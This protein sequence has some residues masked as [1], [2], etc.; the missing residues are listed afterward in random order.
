M[1]TATTDE[2]LA[3]VVD[4]AGVHGNCFNHIDGGFDRV[5][6]RLGNVETRLGNVENR[7]EGLEG[8]FDELI[9]VARGIDRRLSVVEPR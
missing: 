6:Y 9:V 7:V 5:E 3:A 1:S 8:K 2:I 4:P